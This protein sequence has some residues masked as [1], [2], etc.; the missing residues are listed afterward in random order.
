MICSLGEDN[1]KCVDGRAEMV[2]E[3]FVRDLMSV[4]LVSVKGLGYVW[5]M[6]LKIILENSF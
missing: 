3:T 5:F 2:M 1:I 4:C 6:F